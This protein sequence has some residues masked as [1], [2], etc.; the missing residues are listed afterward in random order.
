MRTAAAKLGAE[1]TAANEGL[2]GSRLRNVKA[3]ML[4]FAL[5]PSADPEQRVR[6][7]RYL[8]AATTSLALIP[9]LAVCVLDGILALA[10]FSVATSGILVGVLI[11]YALFRSGLNLRAKDPSLTVP[12]MLSSATVLTYSL[13]HV[14]PARPI[15]MMIYPVVMFFGVFRLNTRALLMV[16]AFILGSYALVVGLLMQQ[17]TGLLQPRL[18]ILQATVLMGVLVWFSF[19]GGY[20]NDL[21]VR[22][23]H[24]EYDELTRCYTRRRIMK[25]LAHEKTR[26]DRGAGPMSILLVDIDQFKEFND[27][28]GHHAG[29]LV[30]QSFV[31][32]ARGELRAIDFLGRY[33]GDEFLLV[34]AQTPIEGARECAERV[35]RQTARAE[36]A[37]P[38]GGCHI[39]VS[40]G[41]A[42]YV[43]GETLEETLRRADAALYRAKA[44]GRNRLECG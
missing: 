35:R 24:S 17:G 36:P 15:L 23:K 41:L 4:K 8:I 44:A 31:K 32:V 33:G 43:I 39:T 2:P 20:V 1:A 25:L 38:Q 13:Y 14:G 19:M 6:F 26:C 10:P 28:L 9:L 7:R 18:E 12:M 11:F 16:C 27:R 37:C 42:Q 40:I 30:L 22:L 3:S 21:R 29:D 34:L 5:I